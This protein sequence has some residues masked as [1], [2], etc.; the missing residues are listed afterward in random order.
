MSDLS[1]LPAKMLKCYI[2]SFQ[3][4]DI[5]I[6]IDSGFVSKR[7]LVESMQGTILVRNS[8]PMRITCQLPVSMGRHGL[9]IPGGLKTI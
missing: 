9:L 1:I 8:Y 4:M 6:L 5:R 2:N 3:E 7:V